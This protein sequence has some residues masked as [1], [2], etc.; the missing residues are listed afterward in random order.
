MT[1]EEWALTL[2]VLTDN[3][4]RKTA[5]LMMADEP[6]ITEEDASWLRGVSALLHPIGGPY[7]HWRIKS[8]KRHDESQGELPAEIIT[9][10]GRVNC[11]DRPQENG[12][13]TRDRTE[14][15][16]V[17]LDLLLALQKRSC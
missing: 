7:Y 5:L 14:K 1:P 3:E 8:G 15:N 4:E 16:H 11:L 17:W 6:W 12:E 10:I 9:T 2:S 13:Y